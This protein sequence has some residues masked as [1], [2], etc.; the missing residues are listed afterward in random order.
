VAKAKANVEDCKR[1]AE[2][3]GRIVLAICRQMAGDITPEFRANIM[4]LE[5]L[6]VEQVTCIMLIA[7]PFEQHYEGYPIFCL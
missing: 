2:R 1:L 6:S 5:K 4:E 7:S 3:A